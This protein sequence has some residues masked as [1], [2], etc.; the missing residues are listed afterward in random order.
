[1]ADL[2]HD[3]EDSCIDLVI[4]LSNADFP[5]KTAQAIQRSLADSLEHV[6][7]DYFDKAG[8]NDTFHKGPDPNPD[9]KD[10][11]MFYLPECWSLPVKIRRSDMHPDYKHRRHESL[12]SWQIVISSQFWVLSWE[13]MKYLVTDEHVQYL[14]HYLKHTPVTD[15]SFVSTAIFN[16]A[17][18][19]AT[20]REGAFKY[21]GKISSGRLIGESDAAALTSCKYLFARKF[22]SGQDALSGTNTSRSLCS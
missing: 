12:A 8:S 17:R 4:N 6:Q 2:H 14:W 15:E 11:H 7:F 9:S 21:I 19:N 20:V 18:L 22:M 5:L 1:M 16:N 13:A 3:Y 10:N